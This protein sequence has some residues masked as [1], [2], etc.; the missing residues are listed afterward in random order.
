ML[1]ETEIADLLNQ[2]NAKDR[3]TIILSLL[4]ASIEE[5]GSFE[6]PLSCPAI[7]A[8]HH[9]CPVLS[10]VQNLLSRAEQDQAPLPFRG[11]HS[12]TAV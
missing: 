11:S 6:L 10:A 9:P 7:P 8:A 12:Q 2:I 1:M 3:L 5:A 4:S